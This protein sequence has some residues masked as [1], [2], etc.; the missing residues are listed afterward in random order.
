MV[1]EPYS[2]LKASGP[3]VNLDKD[4]IVDPNL[5]LVFEVDQ[6]SN[7]THNIKKSTSNRSATY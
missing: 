5:D 1:S 4:K 6:F 7:N 2:T 3:L